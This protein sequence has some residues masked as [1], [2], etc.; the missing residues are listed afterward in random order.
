MADNQVRLGPSP[1]EI[2]MDDRGWIELVHSPEIDPVDLPAG[3]WPLGPTMKVLSISE[4]T[5]ALTGELI[6]PAGY[7]R[8]AG[9]YATQ[10]EWL[11]VSG[12]IRVGDTVRSVGY[13]EFNPAGTDVERIT[14][15]E[16]AVILFL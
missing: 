16:G 8:P 6:L 12:S 5:G 4:K 10:V 1:E 13:Y 14:V 9:H 2:A 7:R 11:V 15:D 3:G